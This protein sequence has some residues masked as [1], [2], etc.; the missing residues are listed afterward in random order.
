MTLGELHA[1]DAALHDVLVE[2][3]AGH[4]ALASMLVGRIASLAADAATAAERERC[5]GHLALAEIGG[6]KL[7]P[8][9]VAAIG[10][11]SSTAA[12]Q[13][14]YMAAATAVRVAPVLQLVAPT[15]Q[16]EATP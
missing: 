9:A 15:G 1:A 3:C 2:A 11:G 8:I 10:D 13:T 12:S 5:V 7:L 14:E 4:V 16:K 6:S